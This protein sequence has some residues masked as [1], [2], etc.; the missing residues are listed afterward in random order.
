MAPTT[1]TLA[2][3]EKDLFPHLGKDDACI[4]CGAPQTDEETEDRSL[5]H[6]TRDLVALHRIRE[7]LRV[8]FGYD[9]PGYEADVYDLL[10]ELE[11]ATRATAPAL[12]E[13]AVTR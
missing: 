1:L 4:Y 9:N 5:E 10:C 6:V 7:T 13:T 3:T 2:P 8:D 11:T 12:A